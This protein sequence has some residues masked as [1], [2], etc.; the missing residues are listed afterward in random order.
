VPV[1][2]VVCVDRSPP[3]ND[4]L[5]LSHNSLVSALEHDPEMCAAVFRKDHSQSKS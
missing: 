3:R 5:R 1:L 4:R 2:G